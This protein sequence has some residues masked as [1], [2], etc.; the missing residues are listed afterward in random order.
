MVKFNN[1][2]EL[3]KDKDL[4][5]IFRQWSMECYELK[6]LLTRHRSKVQTSSCRNWQ[7]LYMCL[8]VYNNKHDN[9]LIRIFSRVR[10]ETKSSE[11]NKYADI[12]EIFRIICLTMYPQIFLNEHNNLFNILRNNKYDSSKITKIENWDDIAKEQP[13]PYQNFCLCLYKTDVVDHFFTIIYSNKEYWLNSS[14]GSQ[15]VLIPQYTTKLDQE[16]KAKFTQFC[17][18]M[19]K[20]DKSDKDK[21]IIIAFMNKFFLTG[22]LSIRHDEDDVDAHKNL[23]PK[24]IEPKVGASKEIHKY[25]DKRPT[26]IGY[27]QNYETWVK[28][29]MDKVESQIKSQTD[30]QAPGG[31]KIKKVKPKNKSKKRKNKSKKRKNKSKKR[32]NKSKKKKKQ[33]QK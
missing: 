11:I 14:Y 23:F 7:L 25:F 22:G 24:W 19:S 15:W 28:E 27:I 2:L 1:C 32:K 33:K 4:I 21:K 20:E 26:Y 5:N 16:D 17:E 8:Y 29:A 10:A 3:I 30:Q 31:K 18:S 13:A 9:E 6:S 12:L